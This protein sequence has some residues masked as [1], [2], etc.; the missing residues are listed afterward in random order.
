MSAT[1]PIL[2]SVKQLADCQ[3]GLTQAAIRWDLANRKTNGL[4]ASGAVIYRGRRILIDR[5]RYLDW[6]TSRSTESRRV[7]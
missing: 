7:A 2:L 6:L 5:G 1:A 4:E 3:P